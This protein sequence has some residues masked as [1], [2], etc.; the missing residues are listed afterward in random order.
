[1]YQEREGYVGGIRERYSK[2]V[3]QAFIKTQGFVCATF[4][5]GGFLLFHQPGTVEETVIEGG[6]FAISVAASYY[7]IITL[8]NTVLKK[9][10]SPP[11]LR[12]Q[13]S[14]LTTD[15]T[16]ELKALLPQTGDYPTRLLG[17]RLRSDWDY[18][19]L[20]EPPKFV[21]G[22]GDN[23]EPNLEIP[24]EL[25]RRAEAIASLAA[26]IL[27]PRERAGYGSDS[28]RSEV[29]GILKG[30][31]SRPITSQQGISLLPPEKQ[32]LLR[33]VTF[34]AIIEAGP[35]VLK[36]YVKVLALI[37]DGYLRKED[38]SPAKTVL[39]R[40]LTD[41]VRAERFENRL[42]NVPVSLSS[43]AQAWQKEKQG[44]TLVILEEAKTAAQ[45]LVAISF[46]KI[47]EA[48]QAAKTA[49]Y[50]LSSKLP[51]FEPKQVEPISAILSLSGRYAG[52]DPVNLISTTK[53]KPVFE[54]GVIH[55]VA[56][57]MSGLD[58]LACA[59]VLLCPHFTCIEAC[60][61]GQIVRVPLR[62]F[63]QKRL[64]EGDRFY[65]TSLFGQRRELTTAENL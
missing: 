15:P 59:V 22:Q 49:I 21:I 47:P 29:L 12:Q 48:S 26:Q 65:F 33:V 37:V 54:E 1:M 24:R 30:I 45:S 57:D 32:I 51:G 16:P 46:R 55:V 20:L 56:S 25:T 2:E 52:L 17:Q 63:Y 13:L 18:P 14:V 61:D 34:G 27:D 41:A 7:N 60:L 64:I 5:L 39:S 23:M 42:V 62:E 28:R 4:G 10:E 3:R 31:L 40:A 11:P 35:A 9:G 6:M 50:S 38:I 44:R 43:Q 53:Q 58:N 8:F 36:D 19:A